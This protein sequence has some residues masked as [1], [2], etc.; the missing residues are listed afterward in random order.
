MNGEPIVKADNTLHL[1]HYVGK[2]AHVKNISSGVS[3]LIT[4][5]NTMLSRFHHCSSD[6]KSSLFQS[7]CTSYYGS[8]LWPLNTNEINRLYV[9]WRKIMRR[10]WKLPHRTHCCLLPAV[11]G[12]EPIHIQLLIRFHNFFSNSLRSSNTQ[13]AFVSNLCLYSQSIVSA[14]MRYCMYM[15]HG[16]LGIFQ[17]N[18]SVVKHDLSYKNNITQDN[19]C[20]AQAVR[21]LCLM[22]DGSECGVLN[23]LEVC[24]FINYLCCV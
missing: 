11:I 13:L 5:T 6:V 15:M 12:C 21:E 17:T 14:N 8:V 3:N 1:G 18:N 4:G 7:Y 2:T 19:I 22:R 10:I 20:V 23:S 24:E 16:D 9:L